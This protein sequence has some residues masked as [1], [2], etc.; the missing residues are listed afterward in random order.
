MK[1]LTRLRVAAVILGTIIVAGTFGFMILSVILGTS[2][3]YFAWL[4]R[5]LVS[6]TYFSVVGNVCSHRAGRLSRMFCC[7]RPT[8]RGLSGLRRCSSSDCDGGRSA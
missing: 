1:G 7:D 3:S 2:M 8:L 6:A 4:A 5:S